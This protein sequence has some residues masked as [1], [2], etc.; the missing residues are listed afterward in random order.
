MRILSFNCDRTLRLQQSCCSFI[1]PIKADSKGNLYALMGKY[2]ASGSFVQVDS[3]GSAGSGN[4]GT[5]AQTLQ[6]E[7][8]LTVD[9]CL[10]RF[11]RELGANVRSAASAVL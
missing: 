9:D 3:I 8:G 1:G 2:G 7:L 11:V 6:G 5:L 10:L 4:A